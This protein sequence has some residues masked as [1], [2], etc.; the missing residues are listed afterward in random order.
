MAARLARDIVDAAPRL[1]LLPIE[2][3]I[4]SLAEL[5]AAANLLGGQAWQHIQ[6]RQGPTARSWAAEFYLR[7]ATDPAVSV[8][9]QTALGDGL[10][11]AAA[12]PLPLRVARYLAISGLLSSDPPAG[13]PPLFQ[14][15]EWR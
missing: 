10:S 12:W 4:E 7:I 2:H 8:W 9:A 11:L 13:Y 15:W 6:R 1:T 14:G 5:M 3:R